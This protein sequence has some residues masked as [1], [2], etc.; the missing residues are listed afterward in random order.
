MV[1]IDLVR[2][3]GFVELA[4]LF[5][6]DQSLLD[7]YR[8]SNPNRSSLKPEFILD[9]KRVSVG[10]NRSSGSLPPNYKEIVHGEI[11]LPSTFMDRVRRE[12][13]YLDEIFTLDEDADREYRRVER[14]RPFSHT[15]YFESD[16]PT[17]LVSSDSKLPRVQCG[18][19][20]DVT[21]FT[22]TLLM[23]GGGRYRVRVADDVRIIQRLEL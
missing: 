7:V 3:Y 4:R 15:L 6:V 13:V 10:M 20:G 18:T 5:A 21:Q 17:F 22:S 9:Q 12:E 19:W 11:V 1:T 16:K 23:F 14:K 2:D 8:I